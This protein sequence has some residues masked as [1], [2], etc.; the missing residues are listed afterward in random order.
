MRELNNFVQ[1]LFFK[2]RFFNLNSQTCFNIAFQRILWSGD[3]EGQKWLWILSDFTVGEP[4]FT[5]GSK[6]QV[7]S[8]VLSLIYIYFTL[9][10]QKLPVRLQRKNKISLGIYGTF[11]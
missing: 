1:R 3:H 9:G 8:F 6:P 4:I 2:L 5:V 11:I 10:F 7:V